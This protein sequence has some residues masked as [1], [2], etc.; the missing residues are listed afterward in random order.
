MKQFLCVLKFELENYF[1]NKS[2][3]IVTLVL[4]VLAAGVVA[5]PSIIGGFMGGDN[6]NAADISD[7]DN[8]DQTL[9]GL[10]DEDSSITDIKELEEKMP[11]YSF[12]VYDSEQELRKAV[13]TEDIAAGF[14]IRDKNTYTY[15]V[16]NN[17]FGGL[18]LEFEDA[19]LLQ[20]QQEYLQEKGL[21]AEE[22]TAVSKPE[23]VSDME[24][25]GK[26][27]VSN[28]VYTY[29]LVFLM[30]VL[31]IFYGQMIATSITAEKSNRAIEILVTSVNSNSLIFGKVL[32]GAVSG[33]AQ[34]V[35]IL[36]SGMISYSFCREAWSG[37]LDFI[38]RIPAAV[39]VAFV[40]FGIMG[41][42]LYAFIYGMLG[43]LVSKTEDI[44]KSASPILMIY[45]ASFMIAMFGMTN[46][47]GFLVKICSFIPFTAS[48]SMF[49]RISMGSVQL[50][51]ILLSGVLLLVSCI[52]AALLAAKI[53][54]YGTLLYGN[55]IKLTKALKNL[56]QQE[57]A[58][59]N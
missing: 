8:S 9:V 23:I 27:S 49:I 3:V 21:T 57:N 20:Y 50:W 14:I 51:E 18:S 41:Y 59:K 11:G 7:H 19:F 4:A 22:I 6:T 39:W 56:K 30:Y 46:S 36:G 37:Q 1:K 53:F 55:P 34:T 28:Y 44:S 12:D 13:E 16:N 17:S 45:I 38:F 31:V 32:A 42:L 5:V 29:I 54:R 58:V 40:C 33:I 48:N 24:I 10:C 26:D 15:V 43:A 2:F 47:D 35:V 52:A 25:L